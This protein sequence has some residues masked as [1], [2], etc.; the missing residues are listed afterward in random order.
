VLAYDEMLLTKGR[1]TNVLYLDSHVAFETPQIL[2]RLG[3]QPGPK[4]AEVPQRDPAIQARLTV[5]SRLKQLALAA[6]IYADEHGGAFAKNL[7]QIEAYVAN[8]TVYAWA[9]Q[10]AVYVAGGTKRIAGNAA[11]RTPIAWCRI[12]NGSSVEAGVAFQDGHAEIVKRARFKDLG[13]EID[14]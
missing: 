13:I 1:G 8:D 14:L 5:L 10:N 3:I 9:R 6:I 11:A 12:P 7:D 4:S 2:E